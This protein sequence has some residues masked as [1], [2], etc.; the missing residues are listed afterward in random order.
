MAH[1]LLLGRL[2]SGCRV[3]RDPPA[4]EERALCEVCLDERQTVSDN[5]FDLGDLGIEQ[6]ALG[7]GDEQR[8]AG[9]NAESFFL[10]LC[11]LFLEL[12]CC[13][14]RTDLISGSPHFIVREQ[15]LEFDELFEVVDGQGGLVS[16]GKRE[17]VAA[18]GFGAPERLRESDAEREVVGVAVEFLE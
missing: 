1:L 9:A 3:E 2:R 16:A 18:A 11:G 12:A 4:F 7:L 6:V 13:S 14:A 15:H 17:R 5:G 10:G 8:C